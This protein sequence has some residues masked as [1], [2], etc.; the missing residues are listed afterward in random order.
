MAFLPV[1]LAKSIGLAAANATI[2]PGVLQPWINEINQHVA[3]QG[4][5][6]KSAVAYIPLA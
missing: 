2:Q 6:S 4:K 3:E 1:M 5:F